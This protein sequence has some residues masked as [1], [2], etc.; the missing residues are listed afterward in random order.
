MLNLGAK[1]RHRAPAL[2]A[3]DQAIGWWSQLRN[4]EMEM[5]K[6]P[7]LPEGK[8]LNVR[9]KFIAEDGIAGRQ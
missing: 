7:K 3:N 2:L 8:R 4:V 5:G 1:R 9:E 6:N